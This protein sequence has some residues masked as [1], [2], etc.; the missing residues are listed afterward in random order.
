M[1]AGQPASPRQHDA[2]Q[3]ALQ[4]NYRGSCRLVLPV[5][6]VIGASPRGRRWLIKKFA[7]STFLVNCLE[8]QG[9]PKQLTGVGV[10]WFLSPA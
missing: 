5:G 8:A 6:A 1:C 3:R 9:Q 2:G 7:P 4:G 10:L